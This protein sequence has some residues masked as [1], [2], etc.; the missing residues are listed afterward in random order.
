MYRA[1]TKTNMVLYALKWILKYFLDANIK[2]L[3]I[4]NN[5]MYKSN[6]IYIKR[7]N[8]L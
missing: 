7:K 8:G 2:I 3:P 1:F 6:L 4:K 5:D